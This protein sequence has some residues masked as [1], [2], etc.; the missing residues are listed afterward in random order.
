MDNTGMSESLS[1]HLP[2]GLPSSPET[3]ER[4]EPIH[5]GSGRQGFRKRLTRILAALGV[6]LAKA[7]SLLFLLPKLKLL[8]TFGSM[9]VS[10]AA[11]GLLFG[12]PFAVGLV[13]LLFLHEIGHVIQLRR[14]GI[15]ASAP[16]FIPFLGAMIA[17]KSM[18]ED[19]AAE[20]RVGL[21]GPVLGSIATLVPLGIW[22]ATGSR[23]NGELAAMESSGNAGEPSVLRKRSRSVS[24]RQ[25][26]INR[27]DAL[28][29]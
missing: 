14:E 9:A 23:R 2:V 18:G 20:A 12:F 26:A 17:A 15:K 27:G 22:L 1:E 3:P 6:L 5:P 4:Y 13:A 19:A 8:A 11:Y 24:D 21:A 7:K 29:V 16:L 10:I 28:A 25:G